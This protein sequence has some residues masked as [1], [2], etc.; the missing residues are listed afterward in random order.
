[1]NNV[2]YC[3]VVQ[4]EKKKKEVIL[5]EIKISLWKIE[6]DQQRS[7]SSPFHLQLD[8]RLGSQQQKTSQKEKN[9]TGHHVDDA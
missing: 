4:N 9:E 1:M 8:C 7:S 3:I 5:G 2:P 6:K